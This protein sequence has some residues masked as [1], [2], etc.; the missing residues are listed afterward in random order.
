MTNILCAKTEIKMFNSVKETETLIWKNDSPR[1]TFDGKDIT[2]SE[3]FT[4]YDQI[5]IVY[6]SFTNMNQ[7]GEAELRTSL[8]ASGL[9]DVVTNNPYLGLGGHGASKNYVRL[10]YRSSSDTDYTKVHFLPC[11]RVNQENTSN[12]YCVPLYIYGIK[13]HNYYP[14][15]RTRGVLA[16]NSA[17]W[18]SSTVTFNAENCYYIGLPITYT[19]GYTPIISISSSSGIVTI[20]EQEAYN[21]INYVSVDDTNMVLKLYAKTKPTS[22]FSILVMGVK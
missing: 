2:L 18:S 1:A 12:N 4:N 17:N 11:Y 6:R 13:F 5:R 21:K 7:L 8:L 10:F 15:E 19:D 22:D 16:V 3:P 9:Y 14:D 20:E